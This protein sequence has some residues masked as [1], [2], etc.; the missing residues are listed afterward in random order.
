MCLYTPA[1]HSI[2]APHTLLV[3]LHPILVD[4]DQKEIPRPIVIQ[5]ARRLFGC[6][7]MCC[8]PR[9]VVALDDHTRCNA[10]VGGEKKKSLP[11]DHHDLVV[12]TLHFEFER[13]VD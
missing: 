11:P 2:K 10:P 8:I 3:N 4:D 6:S 1:R 12:P 9:A 7:G 13:Q 5:M